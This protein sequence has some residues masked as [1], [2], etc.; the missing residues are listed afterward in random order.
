MNKYSFDEISVGQLETFSKT[1]TNEMMTDFFSIT[2]DCNPLHLDADYAKKVKGNYKDRVVY[3][4]LTASFI[5]TLAGVYL[6]GEKSLIHEISVSFPAPV[7]IGDVLT[8]T[9]EVMRKDEKFKVVDV[10]IVIR[11]SAMKKVCRGKMRVGVLI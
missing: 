8:I 1:V 5:S 7:Y 10:K 2:G 11:N 3:G 4:M 6:P 9:G